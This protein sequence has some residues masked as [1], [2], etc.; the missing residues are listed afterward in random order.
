MVPFH[1]GVARV[2]CGLLGRVSLP[3][4]T[5]KT[6][7]QNQTTGSIQKES[8]D[9]LG[10]LEENLLGRKTL[11]WLVRLTSWLYWCLAV[12][13]DA[14]LSPVEPEK[15]EHRSKQQVSGFVGL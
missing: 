4:G 8:P 11:S 13:W 14:S 7:T 10:S 2:S 15:Q 1:S 5:G 6:R 3:S 12:Y 9:Q